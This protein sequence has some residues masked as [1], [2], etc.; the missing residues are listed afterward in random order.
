MEKQAYEPTRFMLPTSHYD[1]EKADRAV[2]FIESLKHTKGTFYNQPFKLLDWQETIVRDL[3]G[4]VKEDGTRQFKQCIAFLSKKNGKQ[5][6]LDTPIPTPQGFTAMGDLKV[7]DTVFDEN[8]VPCHVIA[9]SAVDDTEQAYKLTFRDGTSIIAGARHLW[10]CDDLT[11]YKNPRVTLSTQEIYEKQLEMKGNR[12]AIRIPVA[13]PIQTEDVNLPV[14]PY[15]YGY[16]LGNGTATEARITVRTSDVE[17]IKS[18]IPYELHNIFPQKCGGSSC[19][20]YQELRPILVNNFREKVIRPEYLRASESQRWALLQGLMDSDG[21][22]SKV[23]GQSTYTTTIRPLAESVR[24]L[25]W[26]LGIKNA[27]KAEPSTRNGWPT[28]EILYIIRFTTFTDQPTARLIRKA[29]WSRVRNGDNRSKC[30]AFRWT[31]QAICILLG[32]QWFRH[33]TASLPLRLRCIFSA[34]IM[35]SVQKCMALRRTG[36][37]HHL[38]SMWLPI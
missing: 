9:K 27:V 4:V 34:P 22:I 10:D 33:T 2:L 25:L 26:S 16:W 11:R 15:L 5:L 35:S 24:E 32:R 21:S 12:S 36:R 38:C 20:Y 17:D 28:G 31:V 37:W 1:K 13:K 7:G 8:G 30:S 23:K 19:L 29:V 6:A 3:F 18:N 14:D